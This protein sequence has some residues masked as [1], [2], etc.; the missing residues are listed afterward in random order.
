MAPVAKEIGDLKVALASGKGLDGKPL[1]TADIAEAKEQ[2]ADR[3]VQVAD[4]KTYQFQAPTLTFDRSLTLDFGNREIE[5]KNLGRATTDGDAFVFLPKERIL[6]TGDL[7]VSP[8]P[9][10]GGSFPSEWRDTL[11]VMVGMNPAI[12][13]PGHGPIERDTR[14]MNEV[15]DLLDSVI[16]QVTVMAPKRR[17]MPIAQF[18]PADL[19]IDVERFRK[20]MAGSD[21]ERNQWF[22]SMVDEALVKLA[23]ME[24]TG[25]H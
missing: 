16:S 2:V 21:P 11:R 18:K 3:E 9:Y 14:Y 12:V 10:T 20:S 23:Y 4:F 1:S 8:L 15:I 6:I 19:H 17:A 22:R 13:V 5:I 24:V 25:A 7:V